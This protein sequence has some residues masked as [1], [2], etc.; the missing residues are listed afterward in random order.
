MT[1]KKTLNLVCQVAN[2]SLLL[3]SPA[4]QQYGREAGITP[5]T[6]IRQTI[7]RVRLMIAALTQLVRTF[8][9]CIHK[10]VNSEILDLYF[11]CNSFVPGLRPF[12]F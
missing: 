4:H 2:K 11:A 9:T 6:I 3:S 7:L 12:L 5:K 8:R 10:N 1:K